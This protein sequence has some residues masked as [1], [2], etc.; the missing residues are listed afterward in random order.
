M[1]S[2]MIYLTGIV[3]AAVL[4]FNNELSF[5]STLYS[6]FLLFISIILVMLTSIVKR[7]KEIFFD[8]LKNDQNTLDF[9]SNDKFSILKV[10]TP[11]TV[12]ISGIAF[13]TDQVFLACSLIVVTFFKLRYY[14][15]VVNIIQEKINE[16]Q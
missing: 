2:F 11:I 4:A 16:N 10:S 8:Q 9:V 12:A 7:N 3:V 5:F 14:D 13:Y 6:V 15:T 1:F